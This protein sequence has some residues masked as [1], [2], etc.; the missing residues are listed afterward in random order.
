MID[1]RDIY[2]VFVCEENKSIFFY[3]RSDKVKQAV[4]ENR[5]IYKCN[6]DGKP[7]GALIWMQYTTHNPLQIGGYRDIQI[8][9]I[10][11]T[12]EGRGT[13]RG[14]FEKLVKIA[15]MKGAKHIVLS[16]RTDNA[17]AINFYTKLGMRKIKD[18]MW[19]EQGEPLPGWVMS[20]DI[21]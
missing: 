8:H 7:I 1:Y 4:K 20:Y 13:A 17:R 15:K 9:E 16:V 14:M 18:I 2:N 19:S 3:L 12:N 6:K 10:A 21:R 11:V 5:V